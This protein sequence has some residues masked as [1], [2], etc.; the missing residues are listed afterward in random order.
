MF[1]ALQEMQS[2]FWC[3]LSVVWNFLWRGGSLSKKGEA[4]GGIIHAFSSLA[5]MEHP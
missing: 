4:K 1:V 3:P 2:P 5:C